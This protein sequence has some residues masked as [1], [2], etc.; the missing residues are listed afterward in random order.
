M[1]IKDLLNNLKIKSLDEKNKDENNSFVFINL[2]NEFAITLGN[3][4]R[5]ILLSYING[6]AILGVKI[7]NGKE[8]IKSEFV[9]L[10][11]LVETPPYLILNLK[12]LVLKSKKEFD[13]EIIKLNVNIN[14]NTDNDYKVT[15]NDV[16][17]SEGVVEILNPEIYL[18]TVSPNSVLSIELYC[19]NH[20]GFKK[21]NDQKFL[22]EE[23]GLIV[24]DSNYNPV[25]NV[26]FKVNLVVVDLDK[27]EEQ[28]ILDIKTDGSITPKQALVN[29]LEVSKE[30]NKLLLNELE[31]N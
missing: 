2:P 4:L 3:Y 7:G 1:E 12:N 31:I 19:R 22:V 5:R 10:E 16:K 27:Q 23:E 11:G 9:P 29:A 8:Q 26:S 15:G 13:G 30:I 6:I 21:E 20:W 25:K 24:I 18:G 14:N 17:S 28:L